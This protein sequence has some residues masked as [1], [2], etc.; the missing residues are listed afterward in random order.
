[1]NTSK[2][3][4]MGTGEEENILLTLLLVT[5]LSV[6]LSHTHTHNDVNTVKL[7]KNVLNVYNVYI[8]LTYLCVVLHFIHVVM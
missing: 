2:L 3:W 4:L 6:C 8:Y 5:G 1:M 7:F